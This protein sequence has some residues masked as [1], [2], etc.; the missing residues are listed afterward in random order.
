MTFDNDGQDP[1]TDR[2]SPR[3]RRLPIIGN[4]AFGNADFRRLFAASACNQFGMSGEQVILGLLVFQITQS[5]AWVGV[6]LALYYLPLFIAG[7]VSGAVSDWLDRRRLLRIYELSIAGVLALF[8]VAIAVGLVT[9]WLL[10]SAAAVAGTLRALHG[11]VRMS[12]AYDLVGG[13]RIVASLGLLNI[14]ARMGQLAGALIAGSIAER[15][16]TPFA[17]AALVLAHGAAF[18]LLSR[19]Q[20][21][22]VAAPKTRAPLRQNLREYGVEIRRNRVLLMLI[23]I[24]ASVEVFGFSFSTALPELAETR[25]N[26]GAEGLGMMYAA[27]ATGGIAAGLA[28]A[29]SGGLR[30]RGMVFLMVIYAFGGGLM[31]LSAADQ[32]ALALA[33]L[34]I[35]AFLATASDVLTQSMV[36]LSVANELRGRAMGAW[37]LAIGTAPLGHLQMGVLAV[38]LGVA[39]ALVING[40]ALIIVGLIAT[41]AAPRLRRL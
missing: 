11:P 3:R 39:N 22:G 9:L 21:A 40:A 14:G 37:S 24:T 26:L 4:P 34:V 38:S 5:S 16:G 15:F 30:R 31:L 12:L 25:F 35:V 33:A 17:L 8:A 10:L 27:R 41:L 1:F 13:E 7:P 28:L 29:A 18:L 19:L 20:S 32:F 23:L 2:S 36:Q 6:M